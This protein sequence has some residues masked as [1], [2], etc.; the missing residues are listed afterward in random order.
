MKTLILI[1]LL[2]TTAQAAVL[3]RNAEGDFKIQTTAA[4]YAWRLMA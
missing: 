1:I 3:T 2:I 4:N